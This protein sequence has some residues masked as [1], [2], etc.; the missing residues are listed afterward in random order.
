MRP[1]Q[2]APGSHRQVPSRLWLGA[3]LLLITMLIVGCS[4]DELSP[5]GKDVAA[6]PT[7]GI[8]E[9]GG[10]KE[11]SPCYAWMFAS[12]VQI[13]KGTS[14][15]SGVSARSP[16]DIW[17]AGSG[18]SIVLTTDIKATQQ[19]L[20]AHWN[21]KAWTPI[22]IANLPEEGSRLDAVVSI[23]STDV[24]AVGTTTSGKKAVTVHWD[25]TTA[26]TV[27]TPDPE[28]SA[29]QAT[30]VS[31][32]AT[33]PD[34]V[35]AVGYKIGGPLIMHWNG[36]KWQE[37][38]TLAPELY[39]FNRPDLADISVSSDGNLWAV[40]AYDKSG[41]C[42]PDSEPLVVRLRHGKM[43]EVVTMPTFGGGATPNSVS[44]IANN[45]VWIVGSRGLVLHWD[46]TAWTQVPQPLR[47]LSYSLNAV[48]AKTNTD[49]W[50]VGGAD[51]G[52]ANPPIVMHWDGSTWRLISVP[53][54]EPAQLFYDVAVTSD[55]VWAVGG[56][57]S[58]VENGPWLPLAGWL[59]DGP[60]TPEATLGKII[61]SG[62]K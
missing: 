51:T 17:V 38:L 14:M 24:W 43:W 54:T 10:A 34:D 37:D 47:G 42:L 16:E 55:E 39:A 23:S 4:V 22:S 45:D 28:K 31:V 29:N 57:L 3:L 52:G 27:A 6:A 25:G 40:G 35:W 18:Y 50:A 36:D 53:I 5:S 33:G 13:A 58:G 41:C 26:R 56:T 44:A 59:K 46:G 61:I 8:L 19:P 1:Q 30:L 15:I 9:A 60:C 62:D 7:Q 12:N 2:Q 49:V 11:K 32:A 21:G 20:L 48:T